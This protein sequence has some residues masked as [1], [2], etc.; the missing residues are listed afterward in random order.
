MVSQEENRSLSLCPLLEE[1]KSTLFNMNVNSVAGLDGLTVK[2]FQHSW[3]IIFEEVHSAIMDFFNDSPIPK[4]FSS[5]YIALIPK[6]NEFEA[7]SGL[8]FNKDKG[9]F[10]ISKNVPPNRILDI[11]NFTGFSQA[12]LPLKYLGIPLF[13]GRK[14]TFLFDGL[15]STVHNR[16]ASWDSKFLSFSGRLVLIKS[17]HA[18]IPVY[19]FQVLFPTK[20]VVLRIDRIF[21]KFFWRGSSVNSKIHWSSW[22]K[23][24]G[25]LQEG[26]LGCKSMTDLASAF[27]FKLCYNLRAN[28][29]LWANFMRSKYCGDLHPSN[30]LYSKGHYK[31]WHCLCQIKW[32]LKSCLAWGL[33]EGNIFLWQDRWINGLSLE[34][35]LNTN[36]R[37]MVRVNFFYSAN[38]WDLDKLSS[39]IPDSIIQMI[40]NIS[41]NRNAK[42]ALLCTFTKDGL[43]RTKDAWHVFRNKKESSKPFKMMWHKSIP[44]TVSILNLRIL[45]EFIPT[46]ELL[47]K[48]GLL[49]SSGWVA[50]RVGVLPEA[51]VPDISF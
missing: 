51:L 42:D 38:G 39:I 36:S 10:V 40:A 2:S 50:G 27:S 49:F 14:K 28:V 31:V 13:K 21:N 24:C 20:T 25:T 19:N 41:L 37:S 33:G 47:R 3:H 15:L 18:S 17:V 30:C 22:N 7:V 12:T 23:W 16:L 11:K 8:V 45:K 44:T 6:S 32:K 4:F 1:I 9:C 29:S 5:T 34:A 43:F 48:R 46:D 26:D 35:L